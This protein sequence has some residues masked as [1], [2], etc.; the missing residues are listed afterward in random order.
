MQDLARN[1][2]PRKVRWPIGKLWY[3][4]CSEFGYLVAIGR[5]LEPEI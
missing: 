2:S 5:S 1:C 3:P 4:N